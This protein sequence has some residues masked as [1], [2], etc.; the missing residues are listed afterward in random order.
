MSMGEAKR[1]HAQTQ[2]SVM[3]LRTDGMPVRSDLFDGVPYVAQHRGLLPVAR[4]VNGP[5]AR[6][7]IADKTPQKWTWRPYKPIPAD[8]VFTSAERAFAEPFRGTVMLEPNVKSIGHR[9]KAWSPIFW[10]QLDSTLH[11]LGGAAKIPTV[12][13]G[14]PG[15]RPLIHAKFVGTATFRQACAVLSVCRAFVGT[16][17]GLMH[18]AAALGV[19]GVIIYGGFIGPD[20]TGYSLHRNLFTGSGLGCGMRSDCGHCRESMLKITPTMVLDNLKEI[21]K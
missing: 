12:Q 9:N 2:Q 15:S 13:C 16:E 3:I 4:L 5:G 14:A 18:A 1:L 8:L 20:V 10:Q 19:P 17:G 6:P 7:Y 21:L 11:A